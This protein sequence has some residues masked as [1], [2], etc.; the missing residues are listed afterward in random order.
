MLNLPMLQQKP[1]GW[2]PK[3]PTFPRIAAGRFQSSLARKEN[4]SQNSIAEQGK[5]IGPS[6][7]S[8]ALRTTV[9]AVAS[10]FAVEN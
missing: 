8:F 1:D 4:R 3:I 10:M 5:G 9:L 6:L 7:Y 2:H